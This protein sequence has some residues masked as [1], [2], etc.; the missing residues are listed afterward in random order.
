MPSLA[1]RLLNPNTCTAVQIFCEAAAQGDVIRLVPI[2]QELLSG[3]RD[4]GIWQIL[5]DELRAFADH[6]LEN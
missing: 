3:I 2:R 5:K 6:P 1:L 4:N